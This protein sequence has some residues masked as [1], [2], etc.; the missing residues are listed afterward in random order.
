MDIKL[1]FF[2]RRK[3]HRVLVDPDEIFLD[4]Q[5]LEGFDA[6]QF[7]GKIEQPIS[8][9]TIIGVGIFFA[10]FI[11]VFSGQLFNLQI[12]KGESYYKRSENN[13]LNK[14]I[15]FAD[16]GIIYD[17]NG[18]E[19]AWNSTP[20]TVEAGVFS[21]R[22][23]KIPGFSHVLGY[24]SAPAKDDKGKFWQTEY[25]GKDG[26]EKVYAEE[27]KGQN[28][29]KIIEVDAHDTVHSENIVDT[30]KRGADLY[31]T[32]DARLQSELYR[33][34]SEHA[35]AHN[36]TGGA[37][38]IIDIHTGEILVSTSYPEYDPLVL[39]EGK[40]TPRIRSYLNDKRK[41][42]LDRAVSGLYAP[43][44]IVKPFFALAA[45]AE[46]IIDPYKEILSTGSISIPNP[47]R[48]GEATIF[49][50]WKAHGWTDMSEAIAVSSDVYFYAIGGGFESQKGLGILNIHKYSK[51]FGI[52]EKT[53]VDLPD[54]KS[55]NI[56]SPEWKK[57]VFKNDPWRI[58][59]TYNTSIGQY[60]F[61]VT[62]LEMT[63]ATAAL[64]NGGTL[65]TPHFVHKKDVDYTSRTVN[66][67][68]ILPEHYTH[69][70]EG[71]RETVTYG[72]A[73]IMNV[74]YV[75]VA[76][77]TGTAQVGI[78]K[79]RV[80]S[81]IIGYWPYENPKYAFTVMMET[82]PAEGTVGAAPIM[83]QLLDYMSIYTPEYF[84]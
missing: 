38:V 33:L 34:I 25:I 30:P 20:D 50:D 23:Y 54:E 59:D 47:Y 70:Y 10:I 79:S 7:E 74:P 73:A 66:E 1:R 48:K 56:P 68:K 64:A 60:G 42:F 84:K 9:K 21:Q 6:Q 37:G 63:R 29:A 5:N 12:K 3:K 22:V 41:V 72:T 62:P 69:V 36:F 45:L 57:R 27:L 80:N 14:I 19:L 26:L 4:S 31:T 55:G 77:K 43:G 76:G 67:E 15:I 53:G 13:T 75:E 83:R 32:L 71:M 39:S 82:G 58:G 16:R 46:G 44:S 51:L 18:V 65:M 81:W 28:G 11:T 49:K 2:R 8:R 40:D 52:G 35:T 61:L 24:L 17:R 78:S